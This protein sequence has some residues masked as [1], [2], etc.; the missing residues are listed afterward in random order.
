MSNKIITHKMCLED[1]KAQGI[2]TWSRW[3]CKP[4]TFEWYYEEEEVAYV[5]EGDV[6]V[7]ANGEETHIGPNMLVVFPKGLHCVWQVNE[8]IKKVYRFQ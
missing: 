2:D 8:T 1:A 7:T 6:I 3:E 5:F 4:S